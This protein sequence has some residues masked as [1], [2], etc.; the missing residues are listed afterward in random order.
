M[1]D[2]IKAALGFGAEKKAVSV[3]DLQS[4]YFSSPPLAPMTSGAIEQN[5]V[6]GACMRPLTSATGQG[7]LQVEVQDKEGN[8]IEEPNLS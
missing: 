7:I 4:N 8:W 1:F 3:N 6:I 2:K 5:S